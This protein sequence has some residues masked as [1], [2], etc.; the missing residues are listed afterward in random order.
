MLNTPVCVGMTVVHGTHI[1]EEIFR[2]KDEGENMQVSSKTA[3]G[4]QDPS[5]GETYVCWKL[6]VFFQYKPNLRFWVVAD[7][8]AGMLACLFVDVLRPIYSQV[9]WEI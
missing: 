9:H 6:L 4:G 1:L 3:E 8:F 2:I 5:E 7:I